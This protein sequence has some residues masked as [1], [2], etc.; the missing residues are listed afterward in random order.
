MRGLIS[1]WSFMATVP[2]ANWL[3]HNVGTVCVPNGP[4]LIPVAPGVMAPSG[5]L[6]VGVALVLRDLLQ[7]QYGPWPVV[8]A[9]IAGSA[10]SYVL[11]SPAVAIASAVAFLVSEL[12]DTWVFSYFLR[13]RLLAA[14]VA[15]GIAGAVVD[16]LVFLTIAFGSLQFMPGQVIGKLYA[17]A[18]AGLFLMTYKRRVET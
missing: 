10:L 11:S 9:I 4:C 8:C 17:T 16:S 15:S 18:A 1:V 2:A 12:T 7:K 13:W 6:V 5:V 14:V 3:I